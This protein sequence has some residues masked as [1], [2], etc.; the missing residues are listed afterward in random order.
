[1]LVPHVQFL[2]DRFSATGPTFPELS[3]SRE[4][5]YG[6]LHRRSRGSLHH[7]ADLPQI[8]STFWARAVHPK[9]IIVVQSTPLVLASVSVNSDSAFHSG[10]FWRGSGGGLP[11]IRWIGGTFWPRAMHPR[12]SFRGARFTGTLLLLLP[13][14]VDSEGEVRLLEPCLHPIDF[15]TSHGLLVSATSLTISEHANLTHHIAHKKIQFMK[16]GMN[17]R[18][19]LFWKISSQ[20]R[21]L[22]AFPMRLF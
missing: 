4:F 10:A 21:Y 11:E 3:R 8:R 19:L 18:R 14:L 9:F 16:A 13:F 22:E 6:F 1:M 15:A 12:N 7:R 5:R 2:N 20:D 17:R